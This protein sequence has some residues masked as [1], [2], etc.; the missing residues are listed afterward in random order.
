VESSH[1]RAADSFV[2]SARSP[3]DCADEVPTTVAIMVH[4]AHARVNFRRDVMK[5]L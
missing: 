2:E 3:V 5:Y 1:V 4:T